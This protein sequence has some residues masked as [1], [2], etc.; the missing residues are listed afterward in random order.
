ML[1]PGNFSLNNDK[2]AGVSHDARLGKPSRKGLNSTLLGDPSEFMDLR[3]GRL[4][5]RLVKQLDFLV[6]PIEDDV[7]L[8]PNLDWTFTWSVLAGSSFLHIS[9]PDVLQYLVKE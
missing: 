9:L 5:T 8:R 6:A 7:S 1:V 2:R 3:Y 4:D